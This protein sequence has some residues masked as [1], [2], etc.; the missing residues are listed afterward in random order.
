MN[1]KIAVINYQSMLQHKLISKNAN[2][3][4]ISFD[5]RETVIIYTESLMKLHST[6]SKRE[7]KASL[8]LL[9]ETGAEEQVRFERE[10]FSSASAEAF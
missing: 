8:L 6:K 5:M 3:R 1:G 9:V 10:V 4:Q 2:K 7:A